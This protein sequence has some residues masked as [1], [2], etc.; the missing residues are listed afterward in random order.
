[1]KAGRLS[2]R[3]WVR[4]LRLG[5]AFLW[6]NLV[7]LGVLGG[8]YLMQ[9]T[10]RQ[11]EVA[12][13][14][15]NAFIAG[16]HVS[17]V[18]VVWDLW[19]L[20]YGDDSTGVLQLSGD[21]RMAIGGLPHPAGFSHGTIRALMNS[22]YVVGYSETLGSPVW[23]A[24]RIQD[25]D[26]LQPPPPRPESFEVDART[27]ARISPEAFRKSHYDR[28]HLA[29]NFAIATRFGEVAQRETFLMSNVVP[30]SHALN[31]GLW[32]E[33]EQRIATNYPARYGEVWVFCGPI[34][35]RRPARLARRVAIPE[36]FFMIILDEIE[37]RLRAQ[38]FV[39]PQDPVMS[40]PLA[41]FGSSIDEIEQL[42]G[43]DFLGEFDPEAVA[44]LEAKVTRT[45][46]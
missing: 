20:Y 12:Q 34:F 42:T 8:W 2:F 21:R 36:R 46:W 11:R 30:Q 38:A 29:P 15:R 7:A 25:R 24:Y 10:G 33:L 40:A 45:A 31:A 19:Q 35:P 39:F 41:F 5:R 14:V 22:A 32:K 17:P 4:F 1:V 23:A 18:E 26:R 27:M 43:L 16:K 13:L 3:G 37:G 6:L 44:P 28:G 9:P